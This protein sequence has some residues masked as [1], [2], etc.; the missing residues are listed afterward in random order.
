MAYSKYLL[1]I[2]LAWG[3]I[4]TKA[5]SISYQQADSTSYA[6]Y[7]SGNWQELIVYGR[8]AIASGNDFVLLRLRMGYAQLSTGNYSGALLQY[9]E[10]LRKDAYNLIARYYSY[11]CNLYLN[12]NSLAYYHASKLDTVTLNQEN[13]SSWGLIQTGLETGLKFPDNSLRGTA[14]YTRASLS[15]QLGWRVQL[16]QSL[17]YFHQSIHY[18]RQNNVPF[19]NQQTN[20]EL[21]A[22]RSNSVR[23]TEYYGKLS[24]TPVNRLT[25]I[26]A[27]HYLHTG[28]EERSYHNSL[29]VAGVKYTGTYYDLQADA[30]FS[31]L[32]DTS[33]RQYNVQV[34]LYP[35][36][37]LNLYTITRGTVL[38]QD[39][40]TKPVFS[41]VIGFKAVKNTWLEGSATFGRLNNYAE[42]DGLYLYNALDITTF[43]AS[44]TAY[45]QV[46]KHLLFYLNY[47]Y[48]RKK[49]YYRDAKYNQHSITGGFT[50]KF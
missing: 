1:T 8:Q 42:A 37:N 6:L 22:L 34:T 43:K 27:F 20:E 4:T 11:L 38:Q 24:Y 40:S 17:V 12:R 33:V 30:N 14:S 36:G 46:N 25:L 26:G 18:R 31:R 49:D 15:N 29:E 47:M 13:L 7:Q 48:E 50:W 10:V 21:N 23:Q 35:K 3:V 9:N 28:Y 2:I 39:G 45:Y 44:G 5:Q 32:N 19:N 41:Q 16:D